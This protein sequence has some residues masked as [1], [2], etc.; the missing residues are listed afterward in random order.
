LALCE[1][2]FASTL[3]LP[4]GFV[5]A[6]VNRLTRDFDYDSGYFAY[7]TYGIYTENCGIPLAINEMMLQSHNGVIK[8]F[9][10]FDPYRKAEFHRLRAQGAFLVSAEVDRGF[11]KW[12]EIEPTRPGRCRVRLPW[13]YYALEVVGT[14]SSR[15]VEVVRDGDDILFQAQAGRRYRLTPKTKVYRPPKR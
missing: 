14:N 5:T 1:N 2:G 13:P 3:G 10:A 8:I 7:W 4:N 6:R 15:N 9:P 12:L 11:V